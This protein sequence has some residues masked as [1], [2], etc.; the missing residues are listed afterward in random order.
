MGK[1]TQLI[2][3]QTWRP[4][5]MASAL[6]VLSGASMF[7]MTSLAHAQDASAASGP[8]FGEHHRPHGFGPGGPGM[9][10]L[11]GRHLD[12]LLD[13][14]KATDAQRT[15]IK[16][17]A[18][19]AEADLKPLH[20]ASRGLHDKTLAIFAQPQVNAAAAESLR[21]QSLA[22]HDAASKRMLQVALDISKVLSPEQRATLAAKLQK[23][24]DHMRPGGASHARLEH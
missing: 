22:N 1:I 6:L 17:L 2:H 14:V 4:L 12:H 19:A 10:P 16:A 20:E 9:M 15:Q 7:T 18:K 21:Q 8:T 11:G 13:E 3:P 24:R 5:A 23:H